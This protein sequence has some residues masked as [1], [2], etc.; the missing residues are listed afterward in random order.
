MDGPPVPATIHP[1]AILRAP[2]EL[3]HEE[4]RRFVDDLKKIEVASRKGVGRLK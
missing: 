1:S 4:F 3:R 2:E